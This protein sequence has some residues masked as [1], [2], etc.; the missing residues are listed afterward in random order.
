MSLKKPGTAVRGSTS[1]RPIMAL[2]EL[3][4][5]RWTLRILWELQIKPASFRELQARCEELSPSVL[6][7]RLGELRNARML[8]T[9]NNGYQLT[10]QGMDLIER[11]LPLA[12]WAEHWATSLE[13]PG[14]N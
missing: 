5:R 12:Q 2:L 6:N 3:L 13:S 10:S 1:G 14:D 4:G 9:G 8:E 7:K 11:C